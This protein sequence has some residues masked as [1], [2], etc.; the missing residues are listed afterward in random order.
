MA[1][2]KIAVRNDGSLRVE[3]DF[4]MVD[5]D[6]EAI[7]SRRSDQPFRCAAV[8]IPKPSHSVT[9]HTRGSILR[10]LSR[11]TIFHLSSPSPS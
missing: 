8:V 1:G 2:T 4:E 7:R 10:V 6:G 3:G 11:L 5:Q 9:A